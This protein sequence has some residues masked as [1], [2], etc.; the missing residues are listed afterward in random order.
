MFKGCNC[1]TSALYENA[2]SRLCM[3]EQ[4][5]VFGLGFSAL[6]LLDTLFISVWQAEKK[7]L[8]VIAVNASPEHTAHKI[9]MTTNKSKQT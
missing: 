7:T 8:D 1:Q 4:S 3:C 5:E 9:Y 6:A 2:F